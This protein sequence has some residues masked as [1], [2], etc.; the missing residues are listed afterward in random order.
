M[1]A[2]NDLICDRIEDFICEL[3][4]GA[5]VNRFDV[6]REVMR[7]MS[8]EPP[9]SIV[10]RKIEEMASGERPEIEYYQFGQYIKLKVESNELQTA[11]S[12]TSVLN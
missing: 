9:M 6:R 12:R 3:R 1:K 7:K 4:P 2:T 5:I 8:I 10:D 11:E